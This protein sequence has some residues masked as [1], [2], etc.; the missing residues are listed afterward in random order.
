MA[1]GLALFT[2]SPKGF[3]FLPLHGC[4]LLATLHF[5][6]PWGSR[7]G[8]Q[9]AGMERGRKMVPLSTN[10]RERSEQSGKRKN[11]MTK[12]CEV[13]N[14]LRKTNG[15]N[16]SCILM[17]KWRLLITL[18]SSMLQTKQRFHMKS[19]EIC[20]YKIVQ[21]LEACIHSDRTKQTHAEQLTGAINYREGDC[22]VK[23]QPQTLCKKEAW[24]DVWD[25]SCLPLAK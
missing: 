4:I 16:Q 1:A 24:L 11:N 9:S 20:C 23:N 18:T 7:G 2:P 22:H 19:N 14:T 6:I 15:E 5:W 3:A 17:L 10:T 21:R 25:V 13:G 8:E 12:V